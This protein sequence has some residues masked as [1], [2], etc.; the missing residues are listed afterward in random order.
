MTH[1]IPCFGA[2]WSQHSLCDSFSFLFAFPDERA[3]YLLCYAPPEGV[4]SEVFD[5]LV[6]IHM[7][8][9]QDATQGSDLQLSKEWNRA[10]D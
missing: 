5:E 8:L 4:V 7:S 6:G 3:S 2:G 1:S 9:L 10:T